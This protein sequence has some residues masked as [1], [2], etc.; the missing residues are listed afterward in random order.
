MSIQVLLHFRLRLLLLTLVAR[1]LPGLDHEKSDSSSALEL[2]GATFVTVLCDDDATLE[3]GGAT[4]ATTLDH[5]GSS[6]S[7]ALDPG[8][9][10]LA[11]VHDH[12]EA[13][14]SRNPSP[15]CQ[16]MS[17]VAPGV[18]PQHLNCSAYWC[19]WCECSWSSSCC[20]D[21]S[22]QKMNMFPQISL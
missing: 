12:D 16:P 4:F 3:L 11:T 8:G 13:S 18:H 5:E 10:T 6:S 2:G 15:L 20:E 7:S 1:P 14:L 19:V 21:C 9:A 17:P 22:W